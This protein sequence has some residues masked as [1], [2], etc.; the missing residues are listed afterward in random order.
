MI[1]IQNILNQKK[2]EVNM[3]SVNNLLDTINPDEE[4]ILNDDIYCKK[5]NTPRTCIGLNRKVRCICK[6]QSE[7]LEAE[8]KKLEQME[9]QRIIDKIKSASLLGEK[10]KSVT[11]DNTETNHNP[12]FRNVFNRCRKYCEVAN[13]VLDEGIGIYM[14]G[15]KGTGKSR[16]TACMANELMS[17]YYTVLYTNFSEISKYIRNTFKKTSETESSFLEKLATIDFL[18]ID[19]FG[20]EKVTKDD[21]DLWLQE[22]IFEVINKRYNNNKPIIFTSNYSLQEL[23]EERGLA[24]KTVDRINE[25]C[26]LMKIEGSSYRH[27]V[28]AQREKLF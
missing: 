22:K 26:E 1:T 8:N 28:K 15:N 9:N 27:Q 5:C 7:A 21:Q 6:C 17:K 24:D 16:L 20:T 18:F 12:Q 19:D 11:F 3:Q 10:Y 25:I 13:K 4:Y 14:Y 23:I 2:T